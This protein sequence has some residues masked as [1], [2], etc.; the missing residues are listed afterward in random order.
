MGSTKLGPRF[1]LRANSPNPGLEYACST[2]VHRDMLERGTE[3]LEVVADWHRGAAVEVSR[4][5]AGTCSFLP[6]P[7]S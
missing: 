2:V 1:S 4:I 5:H 7:N 6:P 3:P